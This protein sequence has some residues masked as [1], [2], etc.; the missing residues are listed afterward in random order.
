[1]SFYKQPLTYQCGPFALKYA[2]VMLGK[3]EDEKEIERHAGSTWWSGTTEIGLAKAAKHYDCD[4][5]EIA[6]LGNKTTAL[7]RL[8]NFVSGN[9][10][11]A[12]LC[13]DKWSHWIA[14]VKYES[15]KY[16]CV[17]SGKTKVIIVISE[18]ELVRRWRY[19]EDK[20]EYFSGYGIFP[21]FRVKTRAKFSIDI[22]KKLMSD[23]YET[24]ATGW[25]NYYKVLTEIARSRNPMA[26]YTI[27]FREFLRRNERSIVELVADWN[28][29]IEYKELH[30]IFRNFL[31]L[32]NVYDMVIH[33]NDEKTAIINFTCVL[34]MYATHYYDSYTYL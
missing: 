30:D 33:L 26:E 20:K 8:R 4:F 1:M 3:M 19:V 16:I 27:T 22:V 10:V 15:G 6:P 13:V 25:D 24:L 7:K 31:F 18:A 11:P 9:V 32:A 29:N 23:K 21:N 17:D 34:M 12:V 2:L 14:V 28:G 5:V